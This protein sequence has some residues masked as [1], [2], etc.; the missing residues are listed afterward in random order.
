ML[1]VLKIFNDFSYLAHQSFT[2][3]FGR[4]LGEFGFAAASPGV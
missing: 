3:V 4:G 1:S 2:S